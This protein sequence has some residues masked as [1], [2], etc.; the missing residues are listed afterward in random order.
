MVDGTR[1]E[2]PGKPRKRA[3]A[4]EKRK[5]RQRFRRRAGIEPII[6]HLKSDFRPLRNYL[7]G[8][9]GD[10]INLMLASAA[11]NFK[12]LM[13]QLLDYLFL[14]FQA[15]RVQVIHSLLPEIAA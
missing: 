14:F 13:R 1:I 15:I 4:Y 7:K 10:S 12:K 5:A 3:S 2:I 6:G 9:V 8:S 11:Y